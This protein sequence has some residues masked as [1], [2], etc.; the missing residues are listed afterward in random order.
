MSKA[1]IDYMNARRACPT[2]QWLAPRN[3]AAVKS[4]P[5]TDLDL[6]ERTDLAM[7]SAWSD[8]SIR[9][10][11]MWEQIFAR[12]GAELGEPMSTKY[13][14]DRRDT[15]RILSRYG[16]WADQSAIPLNPRNV[17]E[18]TVAERKSVAGAVENQKPSRKLAMPA[19][20]LTIASRLNCFNRRVKQW[21]ATKAI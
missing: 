8:A 11:V 21:R 14:F 16:L 4:A 1:S 12:F 9:S 19:C 2:C 18:K 10:Q 7:Q 13:H 15:M 6:W 3:R 20:F 17:D 5:D